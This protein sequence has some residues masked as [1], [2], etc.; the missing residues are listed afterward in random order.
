MLK[1][2]AYALTGLVLSGAVAFGANLSLLSGSQYSEPSQV[3]ATVNTVIR[4]I[5][6]GVSGLLNSGGFV[7]PKAT[8][9]TTIEVLGTNTIS[10]SSLA[11]GQAV[12]VTCWG[13]GTATG[14]NTLTIQVGTATAYAVAGAGTTAGVYK[15][16]VLLQKT[17]ASTQSIWSEGVFNTTLILPTIIAATQTDTSPIDVKCSGTSTTATNFT[18]NGMIAEY[19]K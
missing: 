7:G 5:N 9:L 10:A 19:V 17:G 16:T 3:L 11:A 8:T 15:A 18:L 2:I 4:N 6:S 12:K 13:T 14:T 1:R